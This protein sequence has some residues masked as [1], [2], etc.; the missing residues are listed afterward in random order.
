M[1]TL[2]LTVL[3][4][5]GITGKGKCLFYSIIYNMK[6]KLLIVLILFLFALVTV[7]WVISTYTYLNDDID[8][9]LDR[10]GC[11][12][13][14]RNRCEFKDQG[15]CA[16]DKADCETKRDGIWDEKAKYCKFNF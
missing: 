14:N 11:W 1:L 15:F 6:I 2:A 13:Y 12:D 9:C 10:S 7:F 16:K 8:Y 4:F 3:K 5:Q